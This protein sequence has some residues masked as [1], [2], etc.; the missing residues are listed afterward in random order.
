MV[1]RAAE[2]FVKCRLSCDMRV[3]G[4]REERE[5]ES[6]LRQ[7]KQDMQRLYTPW[8]QHASSQR[9]PIRPVQGDKREPAVK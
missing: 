6:L 8:R 7:S 3:E 2:D 4:S 9:Q 5:E 1:V